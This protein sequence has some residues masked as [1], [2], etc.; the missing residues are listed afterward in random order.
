[1]PGTAQYKI[2]GSELQTIFAGSNPID[3]GTGALG[4]QGAYALVR[5]KATPILSRLYAKVT[6]TTSEPYEIISE[7][8]LNIGWRLPEVL[9]TGIDKTGNT[10]LET[11]RH[12]SHYIGRIGF[13]MFAPVMRLDD[14]SYASAPMDFGTLSTT[15][16]PGAIGGAVDPPIIPTSMSPYNGP[17][18]KSLLNLG[19]GTKM[20]VKIKSSVPGYERYFNIAL[21]NVGFTPYKFRYITI[22]TPP[23][24]MACEV[25]S[26]FPTINFGTTGY[27]ALLLFIATP[28]SISMAD[29]LTGLADDSPTS[30]SVK[31]SIVS[32]CGTISSD[33]KTITGGEA[34]TLVDYNTPATDSN[35][36]LTIPDPFDATLTIT[37]T[38]TTYNDDTYTDDFG[39][40]G[41]YSAETKDSS[42]TTVFTVIEP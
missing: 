25:A 31:V 12:L 37:N 8:R 19:A 34:Y 32:Y 23:V 33:G 26:A 15:N 35:I 30:K 10:I 27:G 7:K 16:P 2:N 28:P 21:T 29:I 6:N 14:G 40:V 9:V 39:F 38:D 41:D 1:M 13:G 4:I 18:M 36:T 42:V 5:D 11:G 3:L 20:A 22:P 24:G 17:T